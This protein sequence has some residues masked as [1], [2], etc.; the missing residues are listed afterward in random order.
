MDDYE[1]SCIVGRER[2]SVGPLSKRL[3]REMQG[4]GLGG[5]MGF[6]IT[7]ELVHDPAAG[8]EII[9]KAPNQEMAQRV[10]EAL[11]RE[12]DS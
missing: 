7:A 12:P 4:Q 6:F 5:D 1:M 9:C 11:L 8:A 10:F 3:Y 2:I